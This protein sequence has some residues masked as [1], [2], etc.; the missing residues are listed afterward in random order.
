MLFFQPDLIIEI[1]LNDPEVLQVAILPLHLVHG[2]YSLHVQ[3]LQHNSL[4]PGVGQ[5]LF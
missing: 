4:L 5:T 1:V 3:N 2:V